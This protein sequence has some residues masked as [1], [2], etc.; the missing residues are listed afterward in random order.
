MCAG[1][2]VN[3]R[4]GRVVYGADD[5]KAGA[6]KTLYTLGNDPRLNHSFE[7]TSGVCQEQCSAILTAF[8]REIRQRKKNP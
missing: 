6:L 5:P 3:A 1:M 2:L 4:I 8:F 7:V